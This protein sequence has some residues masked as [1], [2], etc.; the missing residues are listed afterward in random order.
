MREYGAMRK[1][2]GKICISQRKNALQNPNAIMKTRL[3][4]KEYLSGRMISSPITLYDC[5]MPVAGAE[6]FL[7]MSEDEAVK[8]NLKFARI[9]STIERHNAFMEDPIQYR[10][11]WEMDRDELYEM[12]QIGPKDV[13][14]LQ[15]YDDYPV[16]TMMQIEGLGFCPQGETPDFIRNHTLTIEGDFPHNSSGGQLSTGQAGAAGGFIGMVEA[17]RQVTHQ[18]KGTQ[19]A[20]IKHALISGFGVINY[21]RGVCSGAIIISGENE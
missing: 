15:T 2:F 14:L 20:N 1:D 12:A 3:T 10:G 18:A 13:Q 4:M 9:L 11:G 21:D 6:A 7:L 16:I 5:V 8:R 19:V 17:I